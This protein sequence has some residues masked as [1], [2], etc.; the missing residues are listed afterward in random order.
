MLRVAFPRCTSRLGVLGLTLL[1]TGCSC[2]SSD[3]NGGNAKSTGHGGHGPGNATGG[4]SSAM[5]DSGTPILILDSGPS[6][7]DGVVIKPATADVTVNPDDPA[8]SAV[9]FTATGPG[10]A[11]VMWNVSNPDFGSIDSNG[12]FTPT[13]H[14]GGQVDITATVGTKTTK[15]TITVAIG[16]TQNGAAK[17]DPSDPGVGGLGGVGGEG[18]GGAV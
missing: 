7:G 4:G 6:Q 3:D 11:Q 18:L 14:A 17:A 13:G 10:S 1:V 15:V 8:A 9:T 5:F 16:W 12:V 2:S